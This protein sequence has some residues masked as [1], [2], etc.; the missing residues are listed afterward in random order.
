MILSHFSA[1]LRNEDTPHR[2]LKGKLMGRVNKSQAN[3]I[4]SQ[5]QAIFKKSKK[6]LVSRCFFILSFSAQ[7][8][9]RERKRER[10]RERERERKRNKKLIC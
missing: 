2:E 1:L 6:F 4:S 8:Y 10:E 3:V 7:F 5:I 9:M